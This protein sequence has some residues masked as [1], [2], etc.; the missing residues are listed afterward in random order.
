MIFTLQMKKIKI[1]SQIPTSFE[2]RIRSLQEKIWTALKSSHFD[3]YEM[4]VINKSFLIFQSNLKIQ[5]TRK[6]L[7]IDLWI[8]RLKEIITNKSKQNWMYQTEKMLVRTQLKKSNLNLRSNRF[9][10][11]GSNLKRT[12][13]LVWML[14]ESPSLVN[15]DDP[16]PSAWFKV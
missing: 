11:N 15:M 5:L 1:K 9:R 3:R 10:T 16:N 13:H 14:I 12:F 8:F 4:S 2:E 7:T 6:V